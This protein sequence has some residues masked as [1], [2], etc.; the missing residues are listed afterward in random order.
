MIS[1]RTQGRRG[2]RVRAGARIFIAC[3]L[4]T[5]AASAFTLNPAGGRTTS[6]GLRVEFAPNTQ[7]QIWR[8][9]DAQVSRSATSPPSVTLFNSMYL[10]VGSTVWGATCGP[11]V[12]G[13]NLWTTEPQGEVTGAGV[14]GDPWVG[15][16]VVRAGEAGPTLTIVTSYAA[17]DEHIDVRVLI[18]PAMGNTEPYKFYHVI[19]TFLGGADQGPAYAH[20][21][22]GVPTLVGTTRGAVFEAFTSPTPAWDDYFSG[23]YLAAH[24]ALRDGGDLGRR[25]DLDADTDNGIGAQWNLGVVT[26]RRELS[27]RLAF[28]GRAPCADNSACAAPA[29][30]CDPNVGACYACVTDLHCAG[31]TPRCD[32]ALHRC[33]GC[34]VATQSE[35]CA[36][37]A[38][39]ACDGA[40]GV[41]VAPRV[42][43]SGPDEGSLLT[44]MRPPL[45]GH[46]TP[47]Q[48][49]M[50]QIDGLTVG[51]V[52]ADMAGDWSFTPTMDLPAGEHRLQA[53]VSAGPTPTES[54]VHTFS[55]GCTSND[56]CGGERALCDAAR[57]ACV[58]CLSDGD[59]GGPTPRCA[60][61]SGACTTDSD[62]D[63]D[64]VADTTERMIGTDPANADSDGD[65]LTDGEEL[66]DDPGNPRDADGDMHVDALDPDDDDD[67][68]ATRDER[69]LSADR[70]TDADGAPDH[71]DADD[72]GDSIPTAA[73]LALDGSP[74]NDRDMDGASS[75][76]DGDSDGD[77]A[78]DRDE[79]GAD[80]G[81]PRDSDGDGARDFLDGDDD[82]DGLPTAD[83]RPMAADRDTDADGAPDHRDSDDD[84]DT[85]PTAVELRLGDVDHDRDGD[86]TPS[87]R[88]ADSDGDGVLD[89][90]EAGPSPASPADT[91]GAGGPDFLDVDSDN[92]CVP[93]G[94]EGESGAART[95]A[96]LPRAAA[97]ENCTA[98]GAPVCDTARGACTSG[99][100][101]DMDGLAD[102]AEATLG[103]DPARAD[104]DGDGLD[105]GAEV[106]DVARPRDTDADGVIDA[107]DADDDGDDVATRDE[108][109][110]GA[111]RDSDM[112]GTPD[113]LDADDDG[114]TLA[115]RLERAADLSAGHDLDLDG[116]ASHLDADADGDGVE[117]RAEVGPDR[118]APRD[119]DADGARDFLDDDDDGD[120]LP[121]GDERRG[122]TGAA[123]NVDTD[124]DGAFNWVDVDD[125]GD[126]IPTAVERRLDA[127][128]G[129]D[130]DADGVASNL[131]PDADGDGVEDRAE[132][133]ASGAV[134]TAPVDT[135]SDGRPDFLDADSDNDCGAD[136]VAGEAGAAR[137]AAAG[138]AAYCAGA[139]PVCNVAAG[140]C[141]AAR[142]EL[143]PGDAGASCAASPRA[144]GRGDA[145]LA[146]LGLLVGAAAIRR[147]RR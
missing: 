90:D 69:P 4:L 41:C 9:G 28:A 116:L 16:T 135:D 134:V 143:M 7:L 114:D 38:A 94:A 73:E 88:D 119:T 120:G 66:G 31:A 71:R 84:D 112:D 65:G 109:P 136:G 108:R 105:D 11:C 48:T 21:P 33:R 123:V 113:R 129:H 40:A 56:H 100:D 34:A 10:A 53:V 55:L 46:A 14:V 133:G 86:G 26:S 117:D 81:D 118:T 17:P 2:A 76:L 128:T 130:A 70:D 87:H 22:E 1:R 12:A 144:G 51:A 6:D 18:D 63:A 125:D 122:D 78:S 25:L 97:N 58:S 80:P 146:L 29:P 62:D 89:R 3:A 121:T 57:N 47:G 77:G 102:E 23:D 67:G 127:S 82:D 52:V 15:T 60:P 68:V 5:P 137:V 30:Y 126:G 79:A 42:D 140:R 101:V 37:G 39:P 92:D 147:R 83:E 104:S 93:D 59:C 44:L 72:D 20:P 43:V 145:G 54:N 131:D 110:L 85:I 111:D 8:A 49:V 139:T 13:S 95:D 103:T 107:R 75:H 142:Y 74:A 98:P 27:Y 45:T 99:H 24:A 64:G 61:A 35:D 50:V 124:G 141:E 132:A 91:D 138:A 19:D 106:P 36:D 115:T 32:V 96:A